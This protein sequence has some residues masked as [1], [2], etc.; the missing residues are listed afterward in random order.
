MSSSA[1]Q[2]LL[3]N[4]NT[5]PA[6]TRLMLGVARAAAGPATRL[7]AVTGRFGARYISS[8]AA[9]AVAGHAALDALAG[10]RAAHDVV[11]LACF[12]DPG[13][14][15]L[16]ELSPKPVIGMAEASMQAA[17]RRGRFAIVTGGER[18]GPMLAEL[19]ALLGLDKRLARVRTVAPTGADIARD[20]AAAYDLLVRACCE[21]AR[22]GG[23]KSAILGGAGLAG[24]AEIIQPRVPIPLIDSTIAVVKAAEALAGKRG[25]RDPL[26]PTPAVGSVG[27][28]P[29]LSRALSGRPRRKPE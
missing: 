7:T 9:A 21:V 2:L 18:W 11:V 15:A 19:A 14:L 6:M 24:I 8:R 28:S 25:A 22:K 20:P 29:G 26:G 23:A 27:L 17:A 10:H 13:L 5:T 1:P 12:G 4:P 16:R 3:I